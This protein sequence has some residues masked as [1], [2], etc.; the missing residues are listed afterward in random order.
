MLRDPMFYV[1]FAATALVLLVVRH[2]ANSLEALVVRQF[3]REDEASLHHAQALEQRIATLATMVSQP[4]PRAR[5]A[6]MVL[7]LG[8]VQLPDGEQ[9]QFCAGRLFRL[10]ED[11][12]GEFSETM[13]MPLVPGT[14]VVALGNLV[15]DGV[16]ANQRSFVPW[17]EKQ[18]GVPVAVVPEKITVGAQLR[19]GV[20]GHAW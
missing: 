15:L 6:G 3:V 12:R 13:H 16:L 20:R 1:V 18:G 4:P 19:V 10:N 14:I 2:E 17:N 5:L 7:V 9:Q 11:E 8:S